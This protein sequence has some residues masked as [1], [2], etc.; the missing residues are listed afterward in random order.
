MLT[1]KLRLKRLC[2]FT[3]RNFALLNDFV[4]H[5]YQYDQASCMCTYNGEVVYR[6]EDSR[7]LDNTSSNKAYAVA[8]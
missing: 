4:S 3:K 1:Y 6:G 7:G 2:D 8:I 5:C